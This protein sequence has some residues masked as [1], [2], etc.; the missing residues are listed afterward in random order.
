MRV[1]SAGNFGSLYMKF[2]V[3]KATKVSYK[4]KVNNTNLKLNTYYSTDSGKN[5]IQIDANKALTTTLSEYSFTISET[6][7]YDKNRVKFEVTGTAPSDKN[8]QLTIDDVTIFGDGEVVEPKLTKLATP[9]KLSAVLLSSSPNSIEVGWNAVE[10]AGSYV[11]TATPSTGSAVVKEVTTASHIFTGLEYNTEYTISVYA[12]SSDLSVYS[13]SDVA[14]YDKTITTGAKPES[15]GKPKTATIDFESS[16][17]T[18]TFWTFTNM[19]SQQTGSITANGGTYYGTTGGKATASITT[20]SAIASPQS[21]TFYVSKQ[22]NNTSSSS[23]KLQVSS[24]NKTWTDVKTQ[25]AASM[26][27]GT[28]VEVTQDLSSYSNVYVRVYYDGSTAVRNIDDLT[29]TYTE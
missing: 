13:N 10:N 17:D 27:K 4:A 20:K 29:F 26:S 1:Y 23:W 11:V 19:T 22:S 16:S 12:K 18:Y 21:I 6:G 14:T 25:S 7:E 3:S 28:W 2:D 24:D 5:W 9:S 15:G 8:Y